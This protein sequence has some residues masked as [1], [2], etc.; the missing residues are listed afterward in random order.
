MQDVVG[1]GGMALRFASVCPHFKLSGMRL[2]R[3]HNL[4]PN[5][6]ATRDHPPDIIMMIN[7]QLRGF[8]FN[9]VFISLSKTVI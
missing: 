6:G 1:R 9:M 8:I 7:I 2:V 5:R 4:V 3:P